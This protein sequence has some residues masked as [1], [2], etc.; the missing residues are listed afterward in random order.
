MYL[1]ITE[2]NDIYQCKKLNQEIM[3]AHDEGIYD[4]VKYEQSIPY[5]LCGD[6]WEIVP[7][8]KFLDKD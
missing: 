3:D 6:E 4:I 5:I 2:F 8:Y 7:K 1:I